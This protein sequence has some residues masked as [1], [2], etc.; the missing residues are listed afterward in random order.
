M[1]SRARIDFAHLLGYSFQNP[2]LLE[3]ALTHS[4]FSNESRVDTPNNERLEFLGDSVLDLVISEF[5]FE[6]YD[7]KNEGDL[8]KLRADMVCERTLA[9]IGVHFDVGSLLQLG[10][11]EDLMGGRTRRS[12][13]ADAMEAVFGAI[14]LDSDYAT[15]RQL[16]LSTYHKA[17]ISFDMPK[18]FADY[19]SLAQHEF[20][21]QKMEYVV[22]SVTGP[23]HAPNFI[24]GLYVDGKCFGKG[25]GRNKKA[26]EQCAAKEALEVVQ[27][28]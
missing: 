9:Q 23:D 26:A 5:I 14:F 19:K 27:K 21:N 16:I 28:A 12:V 18:V 7:H 2:K 3:E 15:V 1:S 10:K 17:G 25:T 8:T 24:V 20:S 6:Y 13:L 22:E 11:G 4:S